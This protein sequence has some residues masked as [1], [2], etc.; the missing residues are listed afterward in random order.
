[1]SAKEV[2]EEERCIIR[3][4]KTLSR[5]RT[6]LVGVSSS[7]IDAQGEA[8]RSAK[9]V[10]EDSI[11]YKAGITHRQCPRL[12]YSVAQ[13][14]P[15][16]WDAPVLPTS[17][18]VGSPGDSKHG[19]V[20]SGHRMSEQVRGKAARLLA[21]SKAKRLATGP[22]PK[23]KKVR[24]EDEIP[25]AGRTPERQ[26]VWLRVE[27]DS[28]TKLRKFVKCYSIEWQRIERLYIYF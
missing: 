7:V 2:C 28:G 1:M 26:T 18:K 19:G 22:S 15:V 10:E 12:V 4:V 5:W 3:A 16:R 13:K 27:R 20:S 25:G 21:G 23:S 24:G 8:G 14:R 11:E 17:F 9:T 6:G